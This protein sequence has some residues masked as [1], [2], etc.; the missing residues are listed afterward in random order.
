MKITHQWLKRGID[1]F[2]QSSGMYGHGQTYFPIV[3]GSTYK[4]LRIESAETIAQFEREGNAIGG[5]SVG[6]PTELMYEMLELVNSILP[7][8]RP[9][10][11]MGVGT[12]E[13]ILEG[14]ALGVDMFDCVMPTRNGRH[15]VLYTWE[16][17]INIKNQKWE[18]D[19]SPL[20][21]MGTSIVDTYYSKA[22]LRHLMKCEERLAIQIASIHNLAFYLDLMKT[23]REKIS[24]GTFYEWKQQVIKKIMER[25]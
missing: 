2:D 21:P 18:H 20:D 24:N 23:I 3:Q 13:N 4:D 16:G 1:A 22:Y 6:E 10:Y 12:P 17:I 15:G 5:L 11:L 25:L 9:R 7:E 8:E 14:V 19:F